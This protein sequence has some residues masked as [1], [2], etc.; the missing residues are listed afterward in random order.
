MRFWRKKGEE[1]SFEER[2]QRLLAK[3]HARRAEW[4]RQKAERFAGSENW[5]P[6]MREIYMRDFEERWRE[7][8]AAKEESLR[9]QEELAERGM[10]SLADP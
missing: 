10:T 7:Y 3:A 1:E 6:A 8:D 2:R 5:D 9:L 4:E